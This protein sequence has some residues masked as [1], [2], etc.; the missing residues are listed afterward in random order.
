MGS[1]M[2]DRSL[3]PFSVSQW[4]LEDLTEDKNINMKYR[5]QKYLEDIVLKHHLQLVGCPKGIP[6]ANVSNLTGGIPIIECLIGEL[7]SGRLHFCQVSW[8]YAA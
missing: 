2:S 1:C 5:K 4:Y 3:L 7:Q 8:T 6:S